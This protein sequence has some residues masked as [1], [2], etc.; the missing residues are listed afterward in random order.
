MGTGEIIGD[1]QK[2]IDKGYQEAVKDIKKALTVLENKPVVLDDKES[3]HPDARRHLQVSV[4]KSIVRMIAGAVLCT[5]EL[6]WAGSL[7]ILAEG[8]GV[9]E[10][11]V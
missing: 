4:V 8:L 10:E 11:L 9:I 7:L 2:M 3:K 1:T 5:G 6:F